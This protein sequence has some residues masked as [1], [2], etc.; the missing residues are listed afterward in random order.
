[1]FAGEALCLLVLLLLQSPL[2]PWRPR[3][4]LPDD[5]SDAA[6]DSEVRLPPPLSKAKYRAI[7]QSAPDDSAIVL[8]DDRFV[9]QP[10]RRGI[11]GTVTA[12]RLVREDSDTPF[13]AHG[14]TPTPVTTALEE[15]DY[16]LEGEPLKGAKA[17]LFMLPAL[18]DIAGTTLMASVI[19][20]EIQSSGV[21]DSPGA[22]NVGLL[23][24]PVS[25]FQMVRGALPLWVG[26]FSVVFLG[27]R[28][29]PSKWFSLIVIMLGVAL[30]GLAGALDRG[31]AAEGEIEAQDA[32]EPASRV[33]AGV[34]LIFFAQLL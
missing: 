12:S 29:G 18:F 17:F 4:A 31:G 22:Q 11:A 16:E 21:A 20:R 14:A 30:V 34:S 9:A 24:T 23:F 25:V 13:G 19:L 10:A 2:N 7:S 32:A 26:L 15:D 28:L 33:V 3:P 1:M 27:R 5:S 6:D 8:D